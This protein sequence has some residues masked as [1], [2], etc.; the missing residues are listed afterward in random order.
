MSSIDPTILLAGSFIALLAG[1]VQGCTGFGMALIA[2]PALLLIHPP[3]FVTPTVILLSTINTS[4]VAYSAR[5]HIRFRMVG[6]LALGALFGIPAGIWA[7]HHTNEVWLKIA[8]G[9]FVVT[10]AVTL[11]LGWRKPIARA[12]P[13]MVPVGMLSGFCGGSS[14]M[15]GPPVILFLANQDTERDVFRGNIV[16]YFLCINLWAIANFLWRGDIRI[17]I[18]QQVAIFVPAVLLGSFTG[19]RTAP[20]VPNELFKKIAMA[21]AAIMGMVLLVT[22]LYRLYHGG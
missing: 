8:L 16:T 17:E 22:N 13:A 2:A 21:A 6:P 19:V 15:G 20:H 12:M 1:F 3:E 5:R 18:V 4:Y 11:L 7:L 14:S 9:A 10:F